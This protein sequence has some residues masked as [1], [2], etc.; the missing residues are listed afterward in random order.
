MK[1][2][3]WCK[4]AENAAIKLEKDTRLVKE[5]K[6]VLPLLMEINKLGLITNDSQNGI[7]EE[8]EIPENN[9]LHADS[10]PWDD[11]GDNI[12]TLFKK[13]KDTYKKAGGK[14]VHGIKRR[15]R[16]YVSAVTHNLIALVF[17]DRINRRDLVGYWTMNTCDK[18]N[19]IPVTYEAGSNIKPNVPPAKGEL[20]MITS[21]K[22]CNNYPEIQQLVEYLELP[23][24]AEDD[25]IIINVLDPVYGR[26]QKFLLQNILEALKET[27]EIIRMKQKK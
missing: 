12:E 5:T 18:M 16:A 6:K 27:H 24:E 20:P 22:P 8:G 15:S 10:F 14:Y 13:W 11:I 25:D 7:I 4:I 17:I 9:E 21:L 19:L 3:E 2:N 1:L 26:D 23:P